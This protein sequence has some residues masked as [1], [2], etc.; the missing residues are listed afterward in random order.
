[1][2]KGG[3]R[4]PRIKFQGGIFKHLMHVIDEDPTAGETTRRSLCGIISDCMLIL[5]V[6][7][8]RHHGGALISTVLDLVR[9]LLDVK[10]FACGEICRQFS[11]LEG[12]LWPVD[13]RAMKVCTEYLARARVLDHKIHKCYRT[14]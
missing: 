9:T 6:P 1:M 12:N 4:W 13:A 7:C 8:A 2:K 14:Y 5:P 3:V 10:S 11:A